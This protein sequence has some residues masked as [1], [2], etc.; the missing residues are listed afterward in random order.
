MTSTITYLQQHEVTAPGAVWT[1]LVFLANRWI[2]SSK[3][4]PELVT[5]W[6]TSPLGSIA[7][8]GF[9]TLSRKLEEARQLFHILT[10]NTLSLFL[11]SAESKWTL[12]SPDARG[13]YLQ[14]QT[15][16]QW[17]HSFYYVKAT[18]LPS[19]PFSAHIVSL[20]TPLRW[21]QRDIFPEGHLSLRSQKCLPVLQCLA[22]EYQVREARDSEGVTFWFL[23]SHLWKGCLS[24]ICIR[25]GSLSELRT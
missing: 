11:A 1:A 2:V 15:E 9:P 4:C 12:S 25:R 7:L 24:W 22:C 14:S 3:D 21:Q 5:H 10:E 16:K 8:L 19:H 20:Q 23:C 13:I 6:V 18:V 17:C